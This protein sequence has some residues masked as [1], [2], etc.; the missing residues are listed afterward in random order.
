MDS[1]REQIFSQTYAQNKIRENLALYQNTVKP[2]YNELGYNEF[3]VITE[4]I[5]FTDSLDFF[6]LFL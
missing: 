1:I 2:V 6:K 5:V 4:H 3:P